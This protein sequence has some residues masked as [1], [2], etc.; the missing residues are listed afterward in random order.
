MENKKCV[1][2]Q[3]EIKDIFMYC[4]KCYKSI[5]KLKQCHGITSNKTR[6]QLKCVGHCCVY[7]CK[8]I[9]QPTYVEITKKINV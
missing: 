6:C 8:K 2:C 9:N 5:D 7:H 3:V 4:F 1:S